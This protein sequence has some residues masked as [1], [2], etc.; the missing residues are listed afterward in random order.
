MVAVTCMEAIMRTRI[1]ITLCLAA[2]LLLGCDFPSFTGIQC[3]AFVPGDCGTPVST[4]GP[5]PTYYMIGF[6]RAKLDTASTA[7]S[8][9]VRGLLRIGDTVTF[10]VVSSSNFPR[11]TLRSVDWSVDTTTARIT[12]RSDGGMTLQAT[13]LGQLMVFTGS[14]GAVWSACGTAEDVFTCTTMNEMDVVP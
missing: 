3:L 7:M 13:A 10:Y 5:N 4:P 1:C 9:G 2:P 6:P 8:G 12:V 11:D 14:M